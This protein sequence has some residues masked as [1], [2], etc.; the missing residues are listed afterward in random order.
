MHRLLQRQQHAFDRRL[1]RVP[2]GHPLGPGKFVAIDARHVQHRAGLTQLAQ[3]RPELPQHLVGHG[4]AQ[5][6]VEPP[7]ALDVG[8]HDPYPLAALLQGLPHLAQKQPPVGQVGDFV[9][10]RQV[11]DQRLGASNRRQ[12]VKDTKHV[13]GVGAFLAPLPDHAQNALATLQGDAKLQVQST[14][15]RARVVK[16]GAQPRGV[17]RV[18]PLQE[19]FAQH[20]LRGP[21]ARQRLELVAP[22]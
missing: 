10:Q 17:L 1:Q 14:A 8:G 7:K 4:F 2:G 3:T 13:R 21:D 19:C 16:R 9:V 6:L 22:A 15:A 12:I 18:H 20:P 11:V 5:G